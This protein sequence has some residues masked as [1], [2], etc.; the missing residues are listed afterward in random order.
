MA[1][2]AVFQE[3]R[4]WYVPDIDDNR[5]DPEPMRM[6]IEPMSTSEARRLSNRIYSF[7]KKKRGEIH[8]TRAL[9]EK[10]ISTRVIQVENYSITVKSNGQKKRHIIKTGQDLAEWGEE[11]VITDVMKA[12]QDSSSVEEGFLKN[13][14]SPSASLP[15]EIPPLGGN[16]E[17]AERVNLI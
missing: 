8:R 7:T 1:R 9:I 6:L 15:A 10:I 2:E 12:I 4:A 14:D 13:S 17:T 11:A 3:D 16:A 5:D